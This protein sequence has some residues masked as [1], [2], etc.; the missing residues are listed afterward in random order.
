MQTRAAEDYEAA[1]FENLKSIE[2][3]V[4]NLASK[5]MRDDAPSGS[6]PRKRKWQYQDAWSLTRSRDDL[7]G[8]YRQKKIPSNE[9]MDCPEDVAAVPSNHGQCTSSADAKIG[10]VVDESETENK[11]PPLDAPS[12][13]KAEKLM[14]Q[15]VEPLVDSKRRTNVPTRVSRR[16]R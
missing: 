12:A 14:Q 10:K 3:A 5:G 4:S 15:P 6:T 9:P 13:T 1:T 8:E 11:E 2:D 16:V 7:L